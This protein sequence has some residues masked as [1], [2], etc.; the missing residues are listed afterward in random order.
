MKL[1][2]K[3]KVVF[4]LLLLI[5][6][7]VASFFIYK[8]IT[9]KEE[10]KEVKIINKI[11]KYGYSLKETKSSHYK[12][13]FKELEKI[14][15]EEEVNEEEYAKKISEM[16]IYDFYTLSDK[17]AK[18][19]IGGVDFIHPDILENFLINAEDTYYKYIESNI[20]NNRKQ[21][22]PTVSNIE[23]TN[24]EKVS[25]TYGDK[26]DESSYQIKINWSYTDSEFS[27]YQKSA[28]M[29]LV[30]IENKLYIAELQ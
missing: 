26:K 24:I 13:L 20:Y 29:I 6:L 9:K 7:S 22:L 21:S 5:A 18:T 11:D 14:L 17:T 2:K 25:F 8:K 4:I 10:T 3:V 1:K 23:I 16:F 27:T 28:T 12:E 19:D 15:N 30:H